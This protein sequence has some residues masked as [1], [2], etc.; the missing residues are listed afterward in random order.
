MPGKRMGTGR[1]RC[2]WRRRTPAAA[3][4]VHPKRKRSN[5][6]SCACSNNTARRLPPARVGSH[7]AL[8]TPRNRHRRA[9]AAASAP[10]FAH[11]ARGG[12]ID[13][14][15]QHA[16]RQKSFVDEFRGS[17]CDAGNVFALR[18][19]LTRLQQPEPRPGLRNAL[20]LVAP[21]IAVHIDELPATVEWFLI[22]TIEG[23]EL[24]LLPRATR[25]AVRRRE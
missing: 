20:A 10:R 25:G 24:R 14:I 3:D 16:R 13:I 12:T 2:C 5:K 23:R 9:E 19:P 15:R 22:D 7:D 17:A 11:P 8:S 18:E 1:R 21:A 4:R 6:R